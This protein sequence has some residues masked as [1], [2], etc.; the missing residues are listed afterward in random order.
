MATASPSPTLP[1]RG[2]VWP[3]DLSAIV[4]EPPA[5]TSP[6]AGEDGRGVCSKGLVPL[7]F[8]LLCLLSSFPALAAET[9]N[10]F[11]ANVALMADGSVDV[12][13]RIEVNAE[14]VSI[15]RGI[16]RD[17]PTILAN[18]DGS[19]LRS[20]LAVIAVERDGHAEPYSLEALG[21]G[22]QRI[23]IG[24]PDVFLERGPHRYTI[25]YTMTRM[26]R[27]FADHDELYWN[28]TGNYWEFPVLA[29]VAHVSLPEG[30]VIG[31]LAGYTGP[32][33]STER[34]VS[35]TRTSERTATFRSTR[36]LAA[37]EG[38]TV[39]AAFQK[40]V[41]AE[42]QGFQRVVYWLSDHRDL[43]L[44]AVAALLVLL[45]YAFAWSS[46]GRDPNKGVII[47]LF[48]P[49][50]GF[51][52]ALSH[53]VHRM[54]WQKNGWTA[55][56]AAIF[57][58]GVR[59]LVTIDNPARTLKVT[60]T[61]R[62]PEQPL[63]PGEQ[64][65]FDY[66]AGKGSVTVNAAN[67]PQL[68]EKRGEFIQRLETE[69]RQVYFRNNR[70]YVLL[71]VAFSVLCLGALVLTGILDLVF[72]VIA[73]VGGIAV[74]LFTSLAGRIWRGNIAG[75][76][77]LIVWLL[78]AGLNTFGSATA[79][80]TGFGFDAPL[81]GAISIVV[82]NVVFA[83]LMRAPTVQGRK[84]MDHLD[85]FKMYMDTAERNR[86]NMVGEPPMTVERFERILP[87]AIALGVEKPWSE[88][89][90][91]EL[92]RHAVADVPAGGYQPAWYHGRDWST[93]D[94]GFSRT[95]SSVASG[96][97]AA[98]IAAQPAA[99]SSSGFG[100]G[101]GGGGSSGGGGGGGGGGG[102]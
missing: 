101:G 45:Y 97:S 98:M 66:L 87:Y 14:G 58:L 57:D 84:V 37:G 22:F 17:I 42:P 3:G 99:A 55:F 96:M 28:V 75:K 76:L 32:V 81:A 92:A 54:G 10:V 85:G 93:S 33:G 41:L 102:W 94:G 52:P 13:E 21:A 36:R 91:G 68:D 30:A 43:V 80:F 50:R 39:A 25:R 65:I 77:I 34:A 35:I 24:D 9:I 89:F 95:V 71:G 67:G 29:A 48:H 59:G 38:M 51:S 23:R 5:G 26:A 31:D 82:A 61:G 7:L 56:T 60:V 83:I 11:T 4:P 27:L 79:F 74:G 88:H 20:S 46:V 1:A 63:P 62:Q 40:G 2:R 16:Y 72:L 12:T 73:V 86:L 49:P 15:R 69:N 53:Y 100:G 78:I 64:V 18:D 47:P 6:L 44:P 8:V 19:R 90:E 70:G